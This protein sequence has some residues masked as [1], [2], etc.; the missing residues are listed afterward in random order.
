MGK[1]AIGKYYGGKCS[2]KFNNG[3]EVLNANITID[4]SNFEIK[5]D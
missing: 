3:I 2:K 1:E 4:E 5:I